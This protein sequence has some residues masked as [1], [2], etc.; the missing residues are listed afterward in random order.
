MERYPNNERKHWSKYN[1][2][3]E[4]EDNGGTWTEFSNFL[5][6]AKKYNNEAKC[7]G[8]GKQY[9]WAVPYGGDK[10]EC[11]VKLEPPDCQQAKWT[12]VNHLGNTRDGVPANYT[13][14]LPNFPSGEDKRCVLRLR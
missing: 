14:A 9:I 11:L 12:R 5:E 1:N 8:A 3:K 13:W 7:K 6:K 4:C 10:A 2:K